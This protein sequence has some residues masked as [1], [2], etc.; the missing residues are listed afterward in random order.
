MIATHAVRIGRADEQAQ[1]GRATFLALETYFGP[2][3]WDHL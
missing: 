3:L 1:D 2:Q